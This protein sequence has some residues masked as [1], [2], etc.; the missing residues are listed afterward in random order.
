MK[1]PAI[2]GCVFFASDQNLVIII[3]TRTDPPPTSILPTQENDW[4][5]GQEIVG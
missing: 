4:D 3:T 1:K 2:A 5:S